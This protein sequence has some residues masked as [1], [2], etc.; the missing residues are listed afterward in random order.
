MIGGIAI[1]DSASL[2]VLFPRGTP[3]DEIPE[4]LALYEK[5][6]MTRAHKI[7]Q[8]TRL[9]GADLDDEERQSLNSKYQP[10]KDSKWSL[11]RASYGVPAL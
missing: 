4:R 7:Q 1:E 9:T 3:K 8:F 2:C 10:I 11:I 6:R 5:I